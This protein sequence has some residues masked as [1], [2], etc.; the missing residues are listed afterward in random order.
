MHGLT[1]DPFGFLMKFPRAILCWLLFACGLFSGCKDKDATKVYRASKAEPEGQAAGAREESAVPA[2]EVV[3][4]NPPASWEVKP[5]SSMR[6][7]SF[8]V[9]GDSGESADISLVILAGPGGGVLDNINRWLS[10]LGQPEITASQLAKIVSHMG[11]PLG[12]VTLVDLEGLPEG[13]DPAK[14]GRI[15]AGIA[16]GAGRTFFFKM[17]GNAALAGSQKEAFVQW[18]GTVGLARPASPKPLEPG[19]LPP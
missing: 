7:E 9:K 4:G 17:R 6:Q 10:Q 16:S 5:L 11:S 14:D 13:G 2:Q 12:D 1:I 8:L 3:T 18:I 15:V 19:P